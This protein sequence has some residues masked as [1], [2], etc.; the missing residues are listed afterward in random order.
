M[1][2]LPRRSPSSAC[3]LPA[4]AVEETRCGHGAGGIGKAG[5]IGHASGIKTDDGLAHGFYMAI[6]RSADP[7]RLCCLHGK[8]DDEEVFRRQN[9]GTLRLDR[10]DHF[11]SP[12][13]ERNA[14]WFVFD[15]DSVCPDYGR[16][17]ARSFHYDMCCPFGGRWLLILAPVALCGL[18]AA[19]PDGHAPAAP[20]NG[21]QIMRQDDKPKRDHPE[22]EDR[23]EA[24]DATAH[25]G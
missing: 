2:K 6:V 11:V 19:P 18:A 10:L 4:S 14:P 12:F 23:Q 1:P 5:G 15:R 21:G 25:K 20:A 13:R 9:Q 16:V 24:E 22:A 8:V 7:G 3:V 17:G